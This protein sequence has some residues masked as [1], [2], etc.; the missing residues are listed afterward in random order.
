MGAEPVVLLGAGGGTRELIALMRHAESCTGGSVVWPI[1]GI[2][3]DNQALLGSRVA[4]IPV[5]GTLD[6]A[7]RHEG[8][9]FISG[10]A[11]ALDRTI[12]VK[13]AQ[14]MNLEDERWATFVHPQATIV[15]SAV[16][17]PDVIIYPHAVVSSDARVGAHSLVYYG[18]VIHHDSVVGEG[19]CLCASVAIAG[20][21]T[22][23]RSSYLGVGCTVRDHVRIGD[24]VLVGMGAAV[25][26][27]V[28][29]G[30][31][32]AGVPARPLRVPGCNALT[33]RLTRKPRTP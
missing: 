16:L 30:C 19:C 20:H 21:V 13:V 28:P 1:L 11:N 25:V 24:N 33:T 9:M 4:G 2:L 26:S 23:G 18:A 12:R 29:S 7:H 14:R 8:A 6:D 3:D 32:V 10:I 22:I 15:D 27:D 31:T 5:L 17:G